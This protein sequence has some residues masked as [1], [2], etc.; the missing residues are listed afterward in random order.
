MDF[1]R[2]V[3]PFIQLVPLDELP[4]R[5]ASIPASNYGLGNRSRAGAAARSLRDYP[6]IMALNVA[7]ATDTPSTRATPLNFQTLARLRSFS[8]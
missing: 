6:M 5:I 8:T 7:S 3:T 2:F 1:R 4:A